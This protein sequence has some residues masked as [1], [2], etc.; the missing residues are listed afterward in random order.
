MTAGCISGVVVRWHSVVAVYLLHVLVPLLQDNIQIYTQFPW[1][2]KKNPILNYIG[3]TC[4]LWPKVAEQST[5]GKEIWLPINPMK[6]SSYEICLQGT[7][8]AHRL[9]LQHLVVVPR[10][11][12]AELVLSVFFF[13]STT[14]V[15]AVLQMRLP[16]KNTHVFTLYLDW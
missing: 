16:G 5:M 8:L 13:L 12:V 9:S 2:L 14:M 15:F 11:N 1:A 10:P 3:A 4:T 6:S 7:Q